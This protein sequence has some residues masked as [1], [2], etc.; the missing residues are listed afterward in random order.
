MDV[1]R[2]TGMRG[3][4]AQLAQAS[5]PVACASQGV[6]A[7]RVWGDVHVASVGFFEGNG[8]GDGRF[9]VDVRC[10]AAM[11]DSHLL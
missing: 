3:R 2:G 1:N 5:D 4:G 11:H 10:F 7:R 9:L 6:D 8:H